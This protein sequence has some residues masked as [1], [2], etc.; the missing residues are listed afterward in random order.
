MTQ[1]EVEP[2]SQVYFHLLQDTYLTFCSFV[3]L[4]VSFI[5]CF[6]TP[7]RMLCGRK[8]LVHLSNSNT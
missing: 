6:P 5:T 7:G 1:A 3:C 2:P 8:G 4:F